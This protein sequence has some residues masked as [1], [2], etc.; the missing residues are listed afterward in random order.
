[1]P[2][3]AGDQVRGRGRHAPL[4]CARLRRSGAGRGDRVR[5]AERLVVRPAKEGDDGCPRT[6][7]VAMPF[8]DEFDD[9]F[10]YGIQPVVCRHTLTCVR[11]DEDVFVGDVS[12]RIHEKIDAADVVIADMTGAKPNV[13]YEVGYARRAHKPTILICSAG[14]RLEFNVQ[15]ARCLFYEHIHDLE[16]QLSRELEGLLLSHVA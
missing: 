8:D 7:F 1:M 10:H 13:Y 5:D 2:I 12:D 4:F 16:A 14:S 3:P 11:I 9:V 6:C 15:G